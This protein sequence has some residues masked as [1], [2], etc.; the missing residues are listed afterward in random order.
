MHYPYFYSNMIRPEFVTVISV[1]SKT[2]CFQTVRNQVQ[3]Y[4]HRFPKSR[5]TL[6]NS[7]MPVDIQIIF[8]HVSVRKNP[9][10]ERS[11]PL[12]SREPWVLQWWCTFTPSAHS[13]DLAK[14][15]TSRSWRLSFAP[16]LEISRDK[17]SEGLGIAE[18]HPPPTIPHR[19]VRPRQTNISSEAH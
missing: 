3:T 8:G 6:T 9:L 12:P 18:R 14:R 1:R 4:M 15:S 5:V 11:P 10:G 13:P 7:T 19:G 16:T 2:W 17:K